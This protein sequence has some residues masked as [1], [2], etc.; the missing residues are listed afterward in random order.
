MILKL[1]KWPAFNELVNTSNGAKGLLEKP[2]M[3]AGDLCATTQFVRSPASTSMC[4]KRVTNHAESENRLSFCIL[5][6]QC[7]LSILNLSGF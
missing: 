4:V 3:T 6:D 2:V 1:F 5:S 7:M